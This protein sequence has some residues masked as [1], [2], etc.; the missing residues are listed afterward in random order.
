MGFPVNLS[1]S[2]GLTMP[3]A[4]VSLS[5]H[6]C[7]CSVTSGV[8]TLLSDAFATCLSPFHLTL[9]ASLGLYKISVD[10]PTPTA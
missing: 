8:L 6:P 5:L 7:L 2:N 9:A 1:L 3:H 10:Y 4:L